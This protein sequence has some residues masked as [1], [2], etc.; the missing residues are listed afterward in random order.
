MESF[1]DSLI[2]INRLQKNIEIFK[3]LIIEMSEDQHRWKPQHKKWSILEIVHH[4]LDEEKEDFRLRIEYTLE[5]PSKEWE[6]IN[7]PQWVIDRK[8]IDQDF[9][10]ISNKFF[11]KRKKSIDWLKELKSPDWGKTYVHPKIGQISA[12]DLLSSWVAHDFLHIRQIINMNLEYYK[13]KSL[14]YNT[15]YAMP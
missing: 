4:L 1:M 7:P 12:G 6:P 11:A 15:K 9:N 5:D 13:Y 2:L 3:S 10:D 8:Y 14:P